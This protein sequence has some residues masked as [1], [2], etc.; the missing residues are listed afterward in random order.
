[1]ENRLEMQFDNREIYQVVLRSGNIEDYEN[2]TV[3]RNGITKIKQYFENGQMA[4]VPWFA[5]YKGENIITRM[6]A[7]NCIVVYKESEE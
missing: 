7:V 1:M 6:D 2:Y 3:G 5:I 4:A